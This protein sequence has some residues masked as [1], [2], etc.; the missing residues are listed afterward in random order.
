MIKNTLLRLY[1]VVIPILVIGVSLGY[2]TFVVALLALIPLLFL[3][4]RHTVALFFVMYGG[5][6]AGIIRAIYPFIPLYGLFLEVVGLFLMWDLIEDLFKHNL[7]AVGGIVAVLLFFG[8]F[9]LI[10]PE[11]AFAKQKYN[12]MWTHGLFMLAGYYAFERS[13][14]ID[15]EGLTRILLV[16]SMCLFAYVVH[17]AGMGSASLFDYDWFRQQSVMFYQMTKDTG[18]GMLVD[19]QQTGMFLLFALAIFLSQVKLKTG[20]AI[21]YSTCC[22]Q[23]VLV[24]GCRQ[25]ILGVV[26]VIALRFVVFRSDYFNRNKISNFI[27]STTGLVVAFFFIVFFFENVQSTVISST[28]KEG[29]QGRVMLYMQSLAIFH[30]SPMLGRGLGGFNA[31]TGDPWPHNFFLELLCETGVIG[32]FIALL[33]LIIPFI[34]QNQGLLHITTSN[35]FYFLILMAIFVRVMFSGDLRISIELFSAVF[36]ISAV[37]V[38]DRLQKTIK[39]Y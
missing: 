33:F 7:R 36:A 24:S 23:L 32:T 19:Y 29:D 3:T 38:S 4:N 35:Q 1:Y 13:S 25:A 11:S 27:L 21:F 31:I 39:K 16:S 37:R 30:D 17:S 22:M 6:V 15:V 12:V 34:R 8:L 26:L 28:I 20:S 5:V 14:K 2:T 10:G 18:E 9:Y